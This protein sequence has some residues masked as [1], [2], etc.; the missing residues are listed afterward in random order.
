MF[1]ESLTIL[2]FNNNGSNSAQELSPNEESNDSSGDFSANKLSASKTVAQNVVH[3][4]Q[5]TPEESF[6]LDHV[7]DGKTATQQV[8]N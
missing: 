3:R 6:E 7:I 5:K 2:G 8:Q 1:S 4:V